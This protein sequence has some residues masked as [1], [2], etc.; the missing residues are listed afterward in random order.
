V[1]VIPAI[2]LRGGRCV[3]LLQGDYDRETVFSDDPLAVARGW[4]EAGARCLHVV[5]LDGARDGLPVQRDTIAAIV[6][7]LDIPVQVGGGVRSVAHAD[8]LIEAGAR[9]VV[10]GTAA[11]EQ[12]ELVEAL[13]ARHGDERVVVG[14]DARGGKV[15]TRGWTATTDVP[16]ADLVRRMR[17]RGVRRVV[18]TDI[19]RDG[20]LSEPNVAATAAI[21]ALGVVVIASGG[22]ARHADLVRLAGI[23][24]VEAVIVGR[25]LYTGD[26]RLH[27]SEWVLDDAGE[28]ERALR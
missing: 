14:V 3:R 25:A 6:A 21:A 20:T 23:P 12:P 11:I 27:G 15:A 5:D 26:V 7:A 10:V 18:Y 8:A 24:G 22:V 9:R 17:D 19:E 13:L 1:L 28:V 16:A 4:Q 2:D